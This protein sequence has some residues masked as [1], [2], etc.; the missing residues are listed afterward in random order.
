MIF[1]NIFVCVPEVIISYLQ[2]HVILVWPFLEPTALV[3]SVPCREKAVQ[4]SHR[5]YTHSGYCVSSW[6]PYLLTKFSF[7]S[8]ALILQSYNV[9]KINKLKK[10]R[11]FWWDNEKSVIVF[12]FYKLCW[13]KFLEQVKGFSKILRNILV[14]YFQIILSPTLVSNPGVLK[15]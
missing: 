7:Y 9:G 5:S 8:N 10:K 6:I 11:Y 14:K 1:S 15:V 4:N 2:F 12:C 3:L 13:L